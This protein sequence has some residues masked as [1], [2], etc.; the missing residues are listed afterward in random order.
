MLKRMN[1][2]LLQK[3]VAWAISIIY[4]LIFIF[5]LIVIFQQPLESYL[6]KSYHPAISS[7]KIQNNNNNKTKKNVTYDWQDTKSTNL[8]KLVQSRINQ[9]DINTLGLVTQPQA[10]VSTTIVEGVSD[11]ALNYGAGTLREDQKIGQDNYVITAHHVPEKNWA[12]FSGIYFYAQP[13]QN[14]YVTDMSHVYQYKINS[15]KFVKATQVDIVN[16]DR[17][18]KGLDGTKKNQPM[19]T[20]ISC[21]AT[22]NNRITEYGTLTKTYDINDKNVP[23]EAIN[24]FKKSADFKW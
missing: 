6:I 4:V 5:S 7:K 16:K 2:P 1:S 23:S 15:V 24:G 13:G 8:L 18:K 14:V 22:G 19:I 9:N 20:L 11:V 21:D 10:R 12:L 3:I 17:Y